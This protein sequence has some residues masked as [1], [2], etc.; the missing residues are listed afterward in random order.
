MRLA[1]PNCDAKYEVPDD[2]IPEAGRDVQ[3][4]NCGHTWFQMHPATEEA[5]EAEA[6]L[7]GD[8]LPPEETHQPEAAPEPARAAVAEPA[9]EPAA[10]RPAPA[11][12]SDDDLGAAL[13]AALAD[14]EPGPAVPPAAPVA[15]P[16]AAFFPE[17]EDEGPAA[18]PPGTAPKRELDEAVL[19]V[20]REEA[21]REAEARR[22]EA[23]HEAQ[24]AETR[25]ADAE[26][27]MQVQ[28]D[29]GM[30]EAAPADRPGLTATQRRLAML[31]GE[32]PDAP[33]PEPPRPAARRDL[34]PDVEEI[35]STLQ[36]GDDGRDADAMVDS[37]PDLTKGRFGFR[38][39]FLLMIFLLIVA[40]VVYVAA[41]S[42][43]AAIPSLQEPLA[44]YVTFVDGLRLW[45]DEAMN[46]ATQALTSKTG[47]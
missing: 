27:Q 12:L 2:A 13:A 33:P 46:R 10:T 18:A 24:R 47:G 38:T 3:C 4:S 14:P 1:C 40:A 29:L 31:R 7:Y 17:D 22:A 36:P 20:L 43:S 6:D 30:D 32:N 39:G 21:E 26:G 5:A 34:L 11:P 28:P 23:R 16:A 37:L 35:N 41:P 44:A 45:L 25:R 15:P 9:P 8:D 42:L 19:N